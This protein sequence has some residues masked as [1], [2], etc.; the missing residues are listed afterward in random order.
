[1]SRMAMTLSWSK[2]MSS[3]ISRRMRF[4]STKSEK[5]RGIFLMATFSPISVFVAAITMP[6]AP[7][8]IGLI[9]A[10]LRSIS[11]WLLTH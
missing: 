8:P 2:Y 5:A 10:Y 7:E 3:L 1:M 9:G 11:N 6:Y 4:A